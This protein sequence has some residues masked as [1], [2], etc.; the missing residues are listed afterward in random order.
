MIRFSP[1]R[2]L[3]RLRSALLLALLAFA[4]GV[5]RAASTA[6]A[7]TNDGLEV[8]LTE[9]GNVAHVR[10]DGR[11]VPLAA[12]SALFSVRDVTAK[13]GLIPIT[14]SVTGRA[15]SVLLESQ[16]NELNLEIV[17][18]ILNH[19]GRLEIDGTV[20][21]RARAERGIDLRIGLP[22]DLRGQVAGAG[23]NDQA[24][25]NRTGKAAK[26]TKAKQPAKSEGEIDESISDD[27]ALYPLYS[28]T[29]TTRG[30]GLTL[31]LP[32]T[33]PTRFLSGND[34]SGAYMLLRMGLSHYSAVPGVTPFR[35]IMYRHDPQWGFRAALERY[36]A[37][38]REFFFN[39]TRE[40]NWRVDDAERVPAQEPAALRVSRSGFSHLAPSGRHRIGCQREAHPGAS[41]RGPTVRLAGGIRAAVRVGVGRATRDIFVTL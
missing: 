18:V 16:P 24:S 31:A 23:L 17:A 35:I 34:A 3:S 41:R 12:N 1:L 28:V 37:F 19:G 30:S 9:K 5:T 10:L 4:P 32:P 39:A 25:P 40:T 11:D 6:S 22:L 26:A 8:G 33:Y 29:D 7:R 2:T 36:Y 13:S 21:D 38:Y 27:N 20:V 14:F 15:D